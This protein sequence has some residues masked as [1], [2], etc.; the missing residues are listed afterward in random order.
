VTV[1]VSLPVPS[2]VGQHQRIPMPWPWPSTPE[3]KMGAVSPG[4]EPWEPQG[5]GD[6]DAI[7]LLPT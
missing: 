3:P 1:I 4:S 7:C 2:P 5:N 6:R